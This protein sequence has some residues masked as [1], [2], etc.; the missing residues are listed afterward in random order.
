MK[1]LAKTSTKKLRARKIVFSGRPAA[2]KLL[3]RRDS[4]SAIRAPYLEVEDFR[5]PPLL[6]SPY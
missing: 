4:G 6:G 3:V 1:A 5:S 2:D